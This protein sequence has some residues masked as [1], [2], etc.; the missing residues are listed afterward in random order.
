MSASR[1]GHHHVRNVGQDPPAFQSKHALDPQRRRHRTFL[2]A[3]RA[4]GRVAERA[5]AR[6]WF[7]GR[8]VRVGR[9]RLARESRAGEKGLVV[10][11]DWTRRH[12][13]LTSI[14]HLPNVRL[15]GARPYAQVPSYLAAFDVALIPFKQDPVTYITPIPSRRTST[16][17]RACQS[18]RPTC[19]P[20]AD[21]STWCDWPIRPSHFAYHI[22]RPYAEGR[23]TGRQERQAEAARHSW[24]DRFGQFDRLLAEVLV[25]T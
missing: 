2:R 6:Y 18:W 24:D 16:W 3:R 12:R 13:C 5:T 7:R 25:S 19:L 20:C 14:Q 23:D 11:A 22:R 17:R 4:S 1:P 8:P 15:L 10:R 9:Y 21:S